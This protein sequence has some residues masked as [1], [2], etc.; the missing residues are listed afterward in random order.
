M[1]GYWPVQLVAE[2]APHSP[3]LGPIEN[4]PAYIQ[5]RVNAVGCK[6]FE[7]SKDTSLNEWDNVDRKCVKALMESLPW[8]MPQCVNRNG[9]K[10][11]C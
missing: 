4:V 7:D 10:T 2:W 11:R 6:N 5:A 8:R 3:D 1:R 9:W